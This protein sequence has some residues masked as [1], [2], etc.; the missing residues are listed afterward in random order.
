MIVE[1][2]LIVFLSD[3]DCIIYKY[4]GEEGSYLEIFNKKD[5]EEFKEKIKKALDI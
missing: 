4:F 3:G 5:V 2:Y 1:E